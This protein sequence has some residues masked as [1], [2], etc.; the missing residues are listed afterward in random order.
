MP[1][2]KLR[3]VAAKILVVAE[4]VRAIFRINLPYHHLSALLLLHASPPHRST[5][6]YILTASPP[7]R[8]SSPA[9]RH[10]THPHRLLTTSGTRGLEVDQDAREIAVRWR[11]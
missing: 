8:T 7:P 11:S 2:E 3:A 10:P 6:S 5:T 1:A 4:M 9:R